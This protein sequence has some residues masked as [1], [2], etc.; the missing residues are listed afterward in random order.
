M[1]IKNTTMYELKNRHL[2]LVDNN[3][4]NQEQ[5]DPNTENQ[6]LPSKSDIQV[7]FFVLFS[8]CD[9]L[10]ACRSFTEKDCNSDNSKIPEKLPPR[11]IWI[12][13]DEVMA[14][15][16][17]EFAKLSNQ[18][19]AACYVIPGTVKASGQAKSSDIL[20]MQTLLID[21]D[22]G[23]TE[24]KL[25]LLSKT[26]GEPTLIVESGGI[27]SEGSKKLHIYWQLIKA[28][29]GEEL[30]QLLNLRY[31]VA[32]YAGGDLHFK[33]AHQPIRVAG[34]IYHKG[35]NAKLVKIRSYNPVEYTL[36]ELAESVEALANQVD[37]NL[38]NDNQLNASSALPI[39]QILINKI[40]EG[41]Y[42]EQTRFNHLSK[43]IGYWIRRHYDGLI[44]KEQVIDEITCYNLANVTPP[45][46]DAKLK[47]MI[48]GIWNTHI[49]KY[50][51][52]SQ[53]GQENHAD[54]SIN[55]ITPA[56]WQDFPPQ[57]K[58]LIENWLPRGCVTALYGDGGVGKSLLM[59][60]LMTAL[61]VGKSFLGVELKSSSTYAVMCEDDYDEIWRRQAAINS[62]Y[63][64]N[65]QDL[66]N[67]RIVSRVGQDNLLINFDN[68]NN[69]RYTEFYN[70][71]L[72]DIVEHNPD[73][74]ILDTA[75]DM[76][77][78][79]ENNRLHVRQFIQNACGHI[80]RVTDSAVLLCAHPSE[81][82]MQKGNGSCGSTAWN[83]SVRSRWYLKYADNSSKD[84]NIKQHSNSRIL[85]RV[86][87]NYSASGREKYLE[88][89]NGAFIWI[90]VK[91]TKA[92]KT[93]SSKIQN[94]QNSQTQNNK[95]QERIHF[96]IHLLEQQA[97]KGKFYLMKQF[98][99]KFQNH[100]KLG[101]KRSIYD[102]CSV[103][104]T[105]SVI[106]FFNNPEHYG[107]RDDSTSANTNIGFGYICTEDMQ[108]E[109]DNGNKVKILPT[110]LKN[111]KTGKKQVIEIVVEERN[112]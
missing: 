89:K 79:N 16:A 93:V 91:Q 32:L 69:I 108:I 103:A 76:F 52:L 31:K 5:L 47:Q 23:N 17:Y 50:K 30:Q 46:P 97:L 41:G 48:N 81:N 38:S 75:A 55:S 57:R 34:S 64:I 96:I 67:V 53:Y 84:N 90:D 13:A 87:S 4:Y 60:Q 107:I 8:Y 77:S 85:S 102:D 94:G 19:Q 51:H 18:A 70:K 56:I 1:S 111:K 110:H 61:A 104:A 68:S 28:V 26:L 72:S 78:G 54:H 83:N 42:G 74:V 58:W 25:E 71:L 22:T 100:Q 73:L 45:W 105:N 21:I 6:L 7:F 62:L 109:N 12:G 3:N 112:A 43:V 24:A 40:Y 59:Q 2:R 106:K 20:Q 80:A 33:S 14:I 36:A 35:G 95:Q 15:N 63:G 66:S 99:D 82:G 10:I 101:G 27:T 88:W 65:M 86:K 92:T 49:N 98:A 44:S 11:N 29:Q 39:N 9:G 37:N